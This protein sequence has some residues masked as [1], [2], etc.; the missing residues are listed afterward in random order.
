VTAPPRGA[1]PPALTLVGLLVGLLF[2]A[3]AIYLGDWKL[4]AYGLIAF[5]ILGIVAALVG[6]GPGRG[7]AP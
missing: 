5:L 1:R 7:G 6:R 2:V 4:A 3:A